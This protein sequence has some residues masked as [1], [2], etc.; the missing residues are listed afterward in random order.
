MISGFSGSTAVIFKGSNPFFA[1]SHVLLQNHMSLLLFIQ[2]TF[3]MASAKK[4]IVLLCCGILFSGKFILG[5]DRFA[6]F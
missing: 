3:I 6:V 1:Y 5:H 4:A 2:A